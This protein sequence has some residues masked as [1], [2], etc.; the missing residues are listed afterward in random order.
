MTPPGALSSGCVGCGVDL[1]LDGQA[2]SMQLQHGMHISMLTSLCDLAAGL[3][4]KALY[5][6]GGPP[7]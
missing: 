4:M 6:P 1:G 2:Y 7:A 5:T 3:S